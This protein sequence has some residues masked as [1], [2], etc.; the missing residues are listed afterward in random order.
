ML[1]R[2]AARL[3]P[4]ELDTVIVAQHPHVIGDNAKRSAKLHREISRARDT[5]AETLQDPCPQ[6][7]GK[8]LRDPSLRGLPG[9]PMAISR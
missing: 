8:R 4:D 5:L 6:R 9:R 3:R 1:Q 7:V 2:A